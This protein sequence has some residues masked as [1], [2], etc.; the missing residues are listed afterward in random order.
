M[1]VKE[2]LMLDIQGLIK[3]GPINIA[4]FGDSVS[5][6]AFNCYRDYDSV[7]HTRLRRKLNAVRDMVPV[8]MINAGIGGTNATSSLARLERDVL[9]H[10]LDLIIVC[11]GLNDINWPLEDYISSLTEI[12]TK[13]K[14]HC[15]VIFMTP[16]MMNTYVAEDTAE[17]VVTYAARMVGVQNDGKMDEFMDA[18]RKVAATVGVPVCDCY[19]K[20]KELA[21][22]QDTTM[23]LS[24]RVNHPK[25]EMHEL[26][27]DALFEMIMAD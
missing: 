21:K 22:T 3:E 15:D 5:H 20:W 12:L 10:P 8:N 11:F 4:I 14:A 25:E 24:N 27:A 13:C 2:K 9:S 7:Y 16:N 1:K 18:A 6:G 26:F 19:A 23:L 17:D